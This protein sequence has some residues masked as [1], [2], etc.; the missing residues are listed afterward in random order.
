MT[1]LHFHDLRHT[2]NQFAAQSGAA[3]R[4]LMARMGHDSERAAMIYQHEPVAP[5]SSSRTPSTPTSRS[6]SARTARTE[7]PPS[8]RAN[9]TLMAQKI[10]KSSQGARERATE[11]G[12][13]LGFHSWSG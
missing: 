6:S 8:P 3:L 13:D 12:S 5:T 2:G 10:N 1:G 4:D 9:G 11:T 7:Q